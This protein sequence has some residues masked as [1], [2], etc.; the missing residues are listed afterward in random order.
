MKHL[1]IKSTEK[2]LTTGKCN[3]SEEK[4]KRR[5]LEDGPHL[6]YH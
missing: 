1:Y 3:T 6:D 4:K 2:F 5:M